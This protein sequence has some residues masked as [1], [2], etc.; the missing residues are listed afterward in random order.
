MEK[1]LT[2]FVV[3]GKG[4]DWFNALFKDI[5]NDDHFLIGRDQFCPCWQT[6]TSN[7]L[8]RI[9]WGEKFGRVNNSNFLSKCLIRKMCKNINRKYPQGAILIFHRSNPLSQNEFFLNSLKKTNP[10]CKL[11]YW[12]TDVVKVVEYNIKDVIR[13]SKQ[14]YDLVITYEKE[15]AKEYGF[16]YVETPYSYF[17]KLPKIKKDRDIDLLYVGKSKLDIDSSR[18]AKIIKVFEIAKEKQLKVDFTIV[19]VPDECQKYKNDILYNKVIPYDELVKKVTRSKCILEVSQLDEKGTTLRLFEAIAFDTH[20]LFTNKN[21][22]CHPYFDKKYMHYID[23]SNLDNLTI[24]F[25]FLSEN[26]VKYS[27]SL[28]NEISP[29]SFLNRIYN[30]FIQKENC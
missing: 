15:D 23:C 29:Y 14:Y 30:L 8:C 9:A 18:F 12:F 28:K 16:E 6:R 13:I 24:D 4:C 7:F 21:L 20:L 17:D 25:G 1:L 27:K 19:D 22:L 10:K 5:D 2:D 26:N 3:F 11:V